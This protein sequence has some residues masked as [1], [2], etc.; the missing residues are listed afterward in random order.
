[1]ILKS[2][3]ELRI[4]L[5]PFADSKA[6]L[7]AVLKEAKALKLESSTELDIGLLKD[8][9]CTAL[10]SREVEAALE[11]C[12]ARALYDGV[13]ITADTWENADARGDYL[14]VCFEVAKENIG[15]FMKNLSAQFAM[16]KGKLGT[17]QA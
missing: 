6:L 1:M 3:K 17:D 14:E 7:Q 4:T 2:G 11:K 16:L 10:S 15:P 5:A 9:L 12:M 8:A 13:K